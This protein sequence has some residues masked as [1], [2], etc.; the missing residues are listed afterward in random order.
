MAATDFIK[1]VFNAGFGAK[2]RKED[3]QARDRDTERRFKLL[4][5]MDFEPMYASDTTPTYQR[6]ESPIARSY[7]ESFLMGNNPMAT[8]STAPN[9][10]VTKAMQQRQQNEMFGTPAQRVARQQQVQAATP[11][12]VTTPTRPVITQQR[13]NAQ[14]T[15][16]YPKLAR[17]GITS[18]ADF[19]KARD[20]GVFTF[21][22]TPRTP[23]DV[24]E[25]DL[26]GDS[27]TIA[28]KQKTIRKALGG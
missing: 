9:A 8:R 2:Q 25:F 28:R 4:E 26:G 24:A 21:G 17:L 15:A 23:D 5:Q 18:Q 3:R 16:K 10:Q 11:W 13:E 7:L 20:A 14:F 22:P 12:A 27:E 6:T 19:E 1:S